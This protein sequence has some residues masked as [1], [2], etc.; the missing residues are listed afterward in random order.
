[1]FFILR[2]YSSRNLKLGR[3]GLEHTVLL[4]LMHHLSSGQVTK[5]HSFFLASAENSLHSGSNLKEH[6]GSLAA[7]RDLWVVTRMSTSLTG[8]SSDAYTQSVCILSA[9]LSCVSL[10]A[11]FLEP[12]VTRSTLTDQRKLPYKAEGQ[13]CISPPVK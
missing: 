8:D 10:T 6:C 1:M 7:S 4:W 13:T 2:K 11:L 12:T 9:A 3:E 5:G